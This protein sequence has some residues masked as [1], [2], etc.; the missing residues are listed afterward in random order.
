MGQSFRRAFFLG[1]IYGLALGLSSVYW[2]SSVMSGYG[3]LGPVGGFLILLVL[4]AY[5]AVYQGL[6]AGLMAQWTIKEPVMDARLMTVPLLGAVLWAGLDFFKNLVFTGFNWTPL[7]GGLAE[8]LELIGAADL[9][10]IYGLTLIVAFIGLLLASVLN[11]KH[12]LK[13]ALW[14]VGISLT[15]ITALFIYGKMQI[16]YYDDLELTAPTVKVAVIQ[17]SVSQER[18]WDPIFRQEILKRFEY[19][20][21]TA[22]DLKPALIIW[23]ETATPF[24]YGIDQI[25]TAWLNNLAKTVDIPMLVGSAAAEYDQEGN[26]KLYNRAWFIDQARSQGHYDKTHL[27]PFGEYIP[28][29]DVIPFMQWPFAQGLLGAA[30]RYSPGAHT[31][32][33]NL[34]GTHFGVLICFES[35]FPYQARNR[36]LSGAK[37][38]IVTTNDAWFGNSFA[39]NQHLNQAVMR[40]VETRKPLIRAANNGI[41]A[42]I[43]AS[44][45]IEL[46]SVQNDIKSYGYEFSTVNASKETVFVRFGY[47]LTPFTGLITA[48]YA[49]YRLLI[50]VKFKR[51][52]I[53]PKQLRK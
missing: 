53:S 27:V 34:L 41:S 10:G 17:A 33:L 49:L 8:R 2:L 1:W 38:L 13:A 39:P 47:Y 44:G 7:A 18:K 50:R 36:A 23:P 22:K 9:V 46:R 35:I 6:W 15:M 52:P 28:L 40:A 31:E 48:A 26:I 24:V 12:C 43:T 14:Q 32:P 3:G 20:V 5:L 25:E 19:L 21:Q 4:A 45:R 37:F 51:K 42:Q 30:G 11:F 29:A 16:S